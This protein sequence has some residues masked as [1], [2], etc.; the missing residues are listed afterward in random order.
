[1]LGHRIGDMSTGDCQSSA[2]VYYFTLYQQCLKDL[3][4]LFLHQH[5]IVRLS[6]FIHDSVCIKVSCCGFNIYFLMN[7]GVNTLFTYPLMYI[8]L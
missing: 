3:T 7:N 8:Y 5:F 1:L 2:G 6:N 4:A